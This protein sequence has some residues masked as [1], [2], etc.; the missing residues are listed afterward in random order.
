M[1]WYCSC[2]GGGCLL[3][4]NFLLQLIYNVLSISAVQQSDLVLYIYIVFFHNAV[5]LVFQIYTE[6]F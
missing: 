1:I 2:G 3:V 5:V 4:F 6:V